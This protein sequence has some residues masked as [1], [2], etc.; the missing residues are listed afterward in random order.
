MPKRQSYYRE[1]EASHIN[2]SRFIA[3]AAKQVVKR[4]G[5]PFKRNVRGRPLKLEPEKAAVVV[6][7]A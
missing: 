2:S 6:P 4:L 1:Y 7:K 5:A 3:R